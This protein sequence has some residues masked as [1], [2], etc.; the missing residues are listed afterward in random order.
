MAE[1]YGLD[2]PAG[3]DVT[4]VAREAD[5]GSAP[6]LCDGKDGRAYPA[7]RIVATGYYDNPD[8]MGVP[9]EELPT[10]SP[11]GG[12]CVLASPGEIVVGRGSAGG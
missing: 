12:S 10:P 11:P 1:H 2:D 7:R 9:G 5:G 3:E 4:G 6:K 8:Y